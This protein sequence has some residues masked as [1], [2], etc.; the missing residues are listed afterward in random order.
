MSSVDVLL[1]IIAGLIGEGYKGVLT[2]KVS[3]NS[4]L[5][6]LHWPTGTSIT[7]FL[8]YTLTLSFFNTVLL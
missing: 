3:L 6:S 7:K 4:F 5:A 8:L 1:V 2:R